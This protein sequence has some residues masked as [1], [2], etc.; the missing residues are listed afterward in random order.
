MGVETEPIRVE[1]KLDIVETEA[2]LGTESRIHNLVFYATTEKVDTDTMQVADATDTHRRHI[3]DK[4]AA[5]YSG[6]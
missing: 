1:T 4:C 2:E 6:G 5:P 3:S